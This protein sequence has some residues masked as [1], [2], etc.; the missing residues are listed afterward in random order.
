[1]TPFSDDHLLDSLGDAVRAAAAVPESF[2]ATGRA[3]FTWRTV[4]AELA[5]LTEPET[6]AVRGASRVFTFVA[7]ELTIEVEATEEALVGQVTPPAPGRIELTP[8]RGAPTTAEV[9]ALGWFTLRPLPTGLF[10]LYCTPSNGSPVVT[11]WLSL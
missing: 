6:A 8:H 2:L 4:D 9:D 5:T 1:M 7:G 10:R 11:E 3:A